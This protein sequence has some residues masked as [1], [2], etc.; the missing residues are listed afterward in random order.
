MY[1]SLTWLFLPG[2]VEEAKK[3]YTDEIVPIVKKQKR[4]SGL[5]D[6]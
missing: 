5:Q 1:D 3:I 6:A 2:K 4:K